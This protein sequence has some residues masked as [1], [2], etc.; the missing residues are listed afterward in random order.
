MSSPHLVLSLS[1]SVKY[2]LLLQQLDH[3]DRQLFSPGGQE[4]VAV[5]THVLGDNENHIVIC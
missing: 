4:A 3:C 2:S 1:N 5:S